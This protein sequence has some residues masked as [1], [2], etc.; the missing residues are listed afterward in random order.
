MPWT[1]EELSKLR[2]AVQS[3]YKVYPVIVE[4]NETFVIGVEADNEAEA[5]RSVE[6]DPGHLSWC[7]DES[8]A[9]RSVYYSTPDE[10]ER[11]DY[12]EVIDK[13]DAINTE[14][15]NKALRGVR[16]DE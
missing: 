4:I 16:D 10:Q 12:A 7:D 9:T 14:A 2:D 15:E 13:I 8:R 11:K 3:E 6:D 1:D 5:L